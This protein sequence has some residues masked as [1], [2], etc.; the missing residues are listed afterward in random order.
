MSF[1]DELADSA[2]T[3]LKDVTSLD[4]LTLSGAFKV[5]VAGNQIDFNK[6]YA[7]LA[8]ATQPGTGPRAAAATVAA[9]VVAFT[10]IDLDKDVT[11]FVKSNL[12]DA[13]KT[14]LESHRE[15]VWASLEARSAFL[16]MVAEI[17][18]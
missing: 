15:M 14:V 3:L 10:H 13:E 8:K 2:R 4:V 12:T 7:E 18:K 11:Q 6:T 9:E 5:A 16:R 1:I 17:V